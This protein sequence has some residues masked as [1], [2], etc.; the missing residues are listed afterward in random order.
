MCGSCS[1]AMP[2]PLSRT[3]SLTAS[4]V[5]SADK[6]ERAALRR[7][8]QRVGGQVLDRLFEPVRIADERFGVAID[9]LDELDAP[10]LQV[11]LVPLGDALEERRHVDARLRASL[12]PPPSSRARSSRSPMIRSSRCVSSMTMST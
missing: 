3:L 11:A 12:S 10:R 4:P 9:M 1:G 6:R 7:V 8:A 5:R 2:E